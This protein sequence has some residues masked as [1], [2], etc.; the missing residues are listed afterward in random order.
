MF[1]QMRELFQ[2]LNDA[3]RRRGSI[4]F[5]LNEA[6]VII[7]EGGV[8]EAIIAL[9]RNVAHRLI[10]E[11]MLLANETVAS[12]LEAQS[13]PALYR[14]HEE[15]DILKVAKFEE[16]ISGFGYS[17]A[18]PA[19]RAPAAALPEA[20]R[21]DPRQARGEADRVADA[22]DDAEGALRAGEPGPLRPGGAEL[23]AF[24]VADPPLSRSRRPPRAARGAPRLADRRDARGAGPR[25]CRRS[26]ATPRRWS[27][28][29]TMPSA[30]CCSGRR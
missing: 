10:E 25:S 9:Q 4:D 16:F 28:A 27:G 19:E 21:E 1:E 7:D 14:I 26:R 12:Y 30:S 2:I 6:E 22:A 15:P 29:P 5:D 24:H 23:H 18:A 17:L 11:F 20:D 3:R 13:A 8:V